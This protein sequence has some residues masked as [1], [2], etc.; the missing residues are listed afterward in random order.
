MANSINWGQGANQNLIGFG[1][2]AAN[3]TNGWGYS[4]IGSWSPETDLYGIA[5]VL[6]AS[7]NARVLADGGVSEA[8]SCLT[9]QLN[10]LQNIYTPPFDTD[11][12]AF[13]TA[14]A[15]TDTTQQTAINTLV[16]GL[17]T[18]GLWS[19]MKAVYPFV[20]GTASSHKYNLV[21]PVDSDAAFR[22]VFNGGW[23]HSA[24]GA[25]PNGTNGYADT[26]LV[27]SSVLTQDSTHLSFYSR[28]NILNTPQ[29]EI[30]SFTIPTGLGSSS[31]GISYAPNGHFRNRVS[32]STPSTGFIPTDAR[33]LFVSNRTTSTQQKA[34]QNGVLKETASVN[35]NGL[36][37]LQIAI[38]ANRTSSSSVSEYSSKQTA[39]TSIG[40]GLTD[41]DAAN[42]YNRVQAFQ[43]AL[44]RQV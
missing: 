1:Q 39:F 12:Q 22:L 43:T 9:Q 5:G 15:I 35:S 4:H 37:T 13:I 8:S 3:N 34:Y 32:T 28:S 10:S 14:A 6:T 29:F 40:D 18:D 21:N 42:L 33:G 27:P 24:Q 16:E 23:T 38:A 17:K 2:G 41:T 36:S 7:F 11:A 31:F 26:K 30:G 44:N 25:L 19:K 20:G